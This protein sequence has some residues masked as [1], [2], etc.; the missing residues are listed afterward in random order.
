MK[1]DFNAVDSETAALNNVVDGLETNLQHIQQVQG[2]LNAISTGA[3]AEAFQ[4]VAAALNKKMDQYNVTLLGLKT[5]IA[6]VAGTGGGMH[7]QDIA[8]GNKFRAIG[9]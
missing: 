9:V 6:N 4:T 5:A 2:Q 3:G 8:N 7:S 1:Y